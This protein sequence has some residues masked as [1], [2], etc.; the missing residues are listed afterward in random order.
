MKTIIFFCLSLS[1]SA[2]A[3]NSPD[4]IFA[5]LQILEVPPGL[6]LNSKGEVVLTD[7]VTTKENGKF[8][9]PATVPGGISETWKWGKQG[10]WRYEVR[11]DRDKNKDIIAAS[12][13]TGGADLVPLWVERQ[14][15][16]TFLD[17]GDMTMVTYKDGKLESATKC[18]LEERKAECVTV[19]AQACKNMRRGVAIFEEVNHVPIDK[20]LHQCT[21]AANIISQAAEI[22]MP[23][24]GEVAARDKLVRELKAQEQKN[25]KAL[26]N[27]SVDNLGKKKVPSSFVSGTT[28]GFSADKKVRYLLAQYRMCQK[29]PVG[30]QKEVT[31]TTDKKTR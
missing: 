23:Q 24:E 1:A 4:D 7:F 31:S 27:L 13:S 28:E 18:G 25:A 29:F 21:N 22:F 16:K 3:V 26:L 17:V 19:N 5:G 15:K 6:T 30:E 12:V 9:V 20:V 11:L 10:I 14:T 2:F 8:T